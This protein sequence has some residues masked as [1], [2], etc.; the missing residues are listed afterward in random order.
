QLSRDGLCLY[1][2]P[3]VPATLQH[4]H[5]AATRTAA[6]NCELKLG[7]YR[8][9]NQT[10]LVSQF[11]VRRSVGALVAA[12]CRS[13]WRERPITKRRDVEPP[14]AVAG[15]RTAILHATLVLRG[16]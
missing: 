9:R 11:G 16:I 8:L 1:H 7:R 4:Y 12:T 10:M 6:R 2:F 15:H 13:S 14:R 5:P 3:R